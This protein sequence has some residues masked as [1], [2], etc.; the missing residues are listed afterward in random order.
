LAVANSMNAVMAG[1]RQVQGTFINSG[2]TYY[3]KYIF[4]NDLKIYYY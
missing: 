4:V 2:Y 1:A 3:A